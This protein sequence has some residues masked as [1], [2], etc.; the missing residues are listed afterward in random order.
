MYTRYVGK[1]SSTFPRTKPAEVLL[2]F[3][4]LGRV[5]AHAGA[6][7]NVP[8]LGGFPDESPRSCENLQA[9]PMRHPPGFDKNWH[10]FDDADPPPLLPALPVDPGLSDRA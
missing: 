3:A 9:S 10:G 7:P 6:A 4:P 8:G 5:M 2:P 1:E